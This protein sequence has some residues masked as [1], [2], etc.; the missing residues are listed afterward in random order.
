MVL[1][2]FGSNK[3]Y[4]RLA[5]E[6]TVVYCYTC[7]PNGNTS[8]VALKYPR[9]DWISFDSMVRASLAFAE[10]KKISQRRTKYLSVS[11]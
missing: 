4:T 9:E 11:T 6:G 8:V 7:S 10:I 5:M 1:P 3:A 2:H